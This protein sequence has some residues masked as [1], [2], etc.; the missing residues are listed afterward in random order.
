MNWRKSIENYLDDLLD[1][2][3]SP[4][5]AVDGL[6]TRDRIQQHLD[7]LTEDEL[8]FLKVCDNKVKINADR[9]YNH[10]KGVV[11]FTSKTSSDGW[12]WRI[13]QFAT[14]KKDHHKGEDIYA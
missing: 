13:D 1:T 8:R 4:F 11:D 12:W 9:I 5:E 7:E 14:H 2:S 3:V 6:R 10:I